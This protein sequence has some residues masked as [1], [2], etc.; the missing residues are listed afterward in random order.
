[1]KEIENTQEKKK[2]LLKVR[3]KYS[4]KYV[5]TAK[6]TEVYI[7][8]L[9]VIAIA[10]Y[11]GSIGVGMFSIFILFVIVI[12][13]LIL[14]KKSASK[15]YLLFFEDRVVYKRKFLF[16]NKER[17]LKYS[18]IRDIVFTQGLTWYSKIWHKLFKFGDIYVYPKKGNLITHGMSLEVV[19]N[20]DKV[21][22]D[23]KNVIGDKIK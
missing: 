22:E 10:F 9:L 7:I 6:L 2:E 4:I 15:T 21:I 3:K 20:I 13:V 23:I 16:I 8:F 1:M 12:A 11:S 17:V 19:E 5:L 14:S 18:E